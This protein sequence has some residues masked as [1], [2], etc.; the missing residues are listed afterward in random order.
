[1]SAQFGDSSDIDPSGGGGGSGNEGMG[2]FAGDAASGGANGGGWA[3]AAGMGGTGG[4]APSVC[5][6]LCDVASPSASC[7]QLG[8]GGSGGVE[9]S[10][11]YVTESYTAA[12]L[13]PGDGGVGDACTTANDCE[14][15]LGCMLTASGG[16]CRTYCCGGS[17]SDDATCLTRPAAT[18]VG[19]F[20]VPFCVPPDECDLSDSDAICLPD[21]SCT[22]DRRGA[23]LCSPP[24]SGT[25]DEACPCADGFFCAPATDTCRRY[26]RTDEP[27][28]CPIGLCQGHPSFPEGYGICIGS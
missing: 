15:G 25:E 12:C 2:G 21:S 4:E 24:G 27:S 3:G 7:E 1:M 16:L 20:K 17:C 9:D 23:T 10:A 28:D 19:S 6:D 11:C 14:P 22:L 18:D 8:A 26:C 13:E 5:G